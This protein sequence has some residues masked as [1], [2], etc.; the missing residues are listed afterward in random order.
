[1]QPIVTN[2]AALG[3]ATLFY[4]WRAHYQTRLRRQRV[5]CQRV[6]YMLWVMAER[7]QNSDS[8]LWRWS[9]SRFHWRR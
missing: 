5:L 9:E 4:L 2:M 7:I 6:A 1:M 8:G 3:V